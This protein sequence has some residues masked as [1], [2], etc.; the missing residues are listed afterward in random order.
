VFHVLHSR[1][2]SVVGESWGSVDCLQTSGRT[3]LITG[4]IV[5][6]SAP[7]FGIAELAGQ[8]VALTVIDGEPDVFDFDISFRHGA[9]TPHEAV[10]AIPPCAPGVVRIE[11]TVGGFLITGH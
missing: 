4:T 10:Q 5:R 7:G 8:R 2:A 1:G 9:T 11:V 3:A 6:G